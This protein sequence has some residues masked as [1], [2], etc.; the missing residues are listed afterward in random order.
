MF[1]IIGYQ[2]SCASVESGSDG[3][4][5]SVKTSVQFDS[6]RVSVRMEFAAFLLGGLHHQCD[7][8]MVSLC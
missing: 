4:G 8:E 6:V 5:R 1:P 3:V 2:H 7:I